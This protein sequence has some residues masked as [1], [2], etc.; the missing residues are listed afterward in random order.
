MNILIPM[1]GRGSRFSL[2][3]YETP[4]PFIN[5]FGKPM[6]EHVLDN[7]GIDNTFTLCV[8]REHYEQYT[9]LFAMLGKKV[10][11]LNLVLIDK[12]TRGAAD[13][14]LLASM[15]IKPKELLL[16]AN[17]DQLMK[18]DQY[19]FLN[20][21]SKDK[22]D[23]CMF[24]F[25]KNDPAYS[26]VEVDDNGIAIRTAEKQV[27]SE[28]AT[29]GI[30]VWARGEDFIWAAQKM[31]KHEITHAGEY[32][33]CPVFNENIKEGQKIGIYRPIEHWNIGTPDDLK[34]FVK[35][36]PDNVDDFISGSKE[37]YE[38]I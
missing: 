11:Q 1:S 33:V 18:W 32:Y 29:T 21:M 19:N 6:I 31:I 25:N 5:F 17:S 10:F 15:F 7:M 23:G 22:L 26:Y 34:Y 16:I 36:H 9:E 38:N 13:T 27:I 35:M 28:Y 24:V 14:C 8:L 2:N 37:Y 30:Y 4:K 12:V 3:G 20:K